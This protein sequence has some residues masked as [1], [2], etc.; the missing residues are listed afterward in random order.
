M[1]FQQ[2][3]SEL[4]KP[5]VSDR[6]PVHTYST[7]QINEMSEPNRTCLPWEMI[8]DRLDAVCPDWQV[9]YTDPVLVSDYITVRCRLTIAGVTREATGSSKGLLRIGNSEHMS[10]RFNQISGSVNTP[11]QSM[12]NAFVNAA[13]Q[14]GIV[15]RSGDRY[16]QTDF[17]DSDHLDSEHLENESRARGSQ[18]ISHKSMKVIEL[19][20]RSASVYPSKRSQTSSR[21]NSYDR[22]RSSAESRL[23]DATFANSRTNRTDQSGQTNR[24]MANL[25]F[26]KR[27]EMLEISQMLRELRQKS[28]KP[29]KHSRQRSGLNQLKT[30]TQRFLTKVFR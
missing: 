6:Q 12:I 17:A 28:Q 26:T 21:T 10:D 18:H 11:E 24:Q 29:A 9:S 25:S 27:K 3:M 16:N 20:L 5:L 23:N 2:V 15:A 7:K 1:Q 22:D 30:S 13:A 14:F 4:R 19:P 8:R